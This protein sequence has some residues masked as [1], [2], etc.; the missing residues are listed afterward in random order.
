V[1]TVRRIRRATARVFT[2]VSAGVN[3]FVTDRVL[4]QSQVRSTAPGA[5]VGGPLGCS[6][7][8]RSHPIRRG[9]AP[10]TVDRRGRLSQGSHLR[11][12]IEG[13]KT[14]MDTAA[15]FGSTFGC[16]Y[17]RDPRNRR[18]GKITEVSRLAGTRN[19]L[20]RCPQCSA[21]YVVNDDRTIAT[22]ITDSEAESW[23]K[24]VGASDP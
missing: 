21:H 24:Q 3:R 4:D 22:R 13:T 23:R 12:W 18:G 7:S 10:Q 11:A 14:R 19:I 20:L 6:A 1:L 2:K 16:G 17:C 15:E 5:N 9:D 8:R